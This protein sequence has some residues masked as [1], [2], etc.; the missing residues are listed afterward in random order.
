[1]IFTKI[2]KILSSKRAIFSLALIL[3]LTSAAFAVSSSILLSVENTASGMLGESGN[4]IVIAQGNS[5]APFLGTLPLAF[6]GD[7]GSVAGNPG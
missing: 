3:L 2:A 4:T 6:A 7:L 1:M 5:R